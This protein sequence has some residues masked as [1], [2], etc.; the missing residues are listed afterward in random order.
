MHEESV[1]DLYIALCTLQANGQAEEDA[2]L[3]FARPAG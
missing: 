1:Q 3:L 2:L